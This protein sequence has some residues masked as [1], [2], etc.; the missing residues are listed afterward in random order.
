[1]R[2]TARGGKMPEPNRKSVRGSIGFGR[3]AMLIHSTRNVEHS[4][5]LLLRYPTM[6]LSFS[7]DDH[8]ASFLVNIER[9]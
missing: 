9:I 5:F 3:L 7:A 2:T 8:S 1:M 6:F 4:L